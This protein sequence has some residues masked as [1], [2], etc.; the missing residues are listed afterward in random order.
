MKKL[1]PLY[2]LAVLT[3]SC[4]HAARADTFVV[5]SALATGAGSLREAIEKGQCQRHCRY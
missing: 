3:L 5:T 4:F 2:L 1:H